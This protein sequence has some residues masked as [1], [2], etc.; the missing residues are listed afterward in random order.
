M[1]QRQ[2]GEVEFPRYEVRDKRNPDLAY[3]CGPWPDAEAA[4]A[5]FNTA[6]G[7]TVGRTFTTVPAG[8][9][10]ADY[11]LIEQEKSGQIGLRDIEEIYLYLR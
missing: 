5:H 8:P 2:A 3:P 9:G 11:V 4:I 10:C 6:Y 7:P 1:Q